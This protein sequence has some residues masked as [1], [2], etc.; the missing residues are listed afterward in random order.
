MLRC[1]GMLCGSP[2]FTSL[3]EPTQLASLYIL[4]P[5]K[6]VTKRSSCA[7]VEAIARFT[8]KEGTA[9]KARRGEEEA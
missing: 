1:R 7:L 3:N 2:W 9:G 5:S 8:I 6:E 4:V